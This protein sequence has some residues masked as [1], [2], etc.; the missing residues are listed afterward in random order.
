MGDLPSFFGVNT[1]SYIYSHAAEACLEEWAARGHSH[2]ELMIYP[3]H[4]WPKDMDARA[5]RAFRRRLEGRGVTL[6]TLNMPNIDLNIAAAAP[7]MRALSVEHLTRAFELA[8]DL[9]AGSVVVGPGK[10]NP[11]FPQPAAQLTGWFFEALDAL[12]PLAARL[13]VRVLIENMPFAF[14][15]KAEEMMRALDDYGADAIGVVYDVA[16][17]VFAREDPA[18]GLKRVAPRLALVHL[19]DTGLAAYRHDPVGAGVVPFDAFARALDAVGYTGPAMLEII[20]TKPDDDIPASVARLLGDPAWRK[21][22]DERVAVE[23]R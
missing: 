11:L 21:L 18:A 22:A 20:S 6:T 16:N 17:A 2:F 19:S 7:E 5:R 15:P 9:G 23:A 14:L 10:P 8:G 12:V 1:Y 13:G 3:G 4:L